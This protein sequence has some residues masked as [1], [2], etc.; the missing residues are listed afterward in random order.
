MANLKNNISLVC[1]NCPLRGRCD[2]F[3]RIPYPRKAMTRQRLCV[4]TV[5]DLMIGVIA[6]IL[7]SM[8]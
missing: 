4:R 8:L 6:A 5:G 3:S 1:S 2:F 7:V